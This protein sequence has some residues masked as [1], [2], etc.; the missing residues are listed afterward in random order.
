[1]QNLNLG[2]ALFANRDF[3]VGNGFLVNVQRLTDQ[4]ELINIFRAENGSARG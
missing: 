3:S 1:V 2:N 4:F